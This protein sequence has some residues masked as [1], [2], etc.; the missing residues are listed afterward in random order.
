[1]WLDLWDA[2]LRLFTNVI[3]ALVSLH[4][5]L[6]LTKI[7]DS[8]LNARLKVSDMRGL[9]SLA[10]RL[11]NLKTLGF[12]LASVAI[13][14]GVAGYE[15][16]DDPLSPLAWFLNGYSANIV[17]ELGSIALTVIIIDG[18]SERRARKQEKRRLIAQMASVNNSSA[19]DAVRL[20]RIEGWLSDG[21][22]AKADFSGA[23][24]RNAD[25]SGAVLTEAR[26]KGACLIDARFDRAVLD[27]VDLAKADL[28]GARLVDCSMHR[29]NLFSARLDHTDLSYSSLTSAVLLNAHLQNA[30]LNNTILTD[31][32][33]T[34]ADLSSATLI[35]TRVTEPQLQRARSLHDA[36][37]DIARDP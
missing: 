30:D 3:A 12:I 21:S 5:L 1:M 14:I 2:V 22:L 24:L 17:T 8:G 36:R 34:G 35:G 11:L 20:L 23:D 32:D 4:C 37:L 19:L 27:K 33:L 26:F 31:A 9:T 28:S 25:L 15:L 29:A 6:P 7:R 13:I 16:H 10:D 18:L